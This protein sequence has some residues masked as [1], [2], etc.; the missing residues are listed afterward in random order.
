MISIQPVTPTNVAP[1]NPVVLSSTARDAD[2]WKWMKG[3]ANVPGAT[4]TG[5]VATLNIQS[6]Q[7]I[8]TGNYKVVF[9]NALGSVNSNIAVVTVAQP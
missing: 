6:A 7:T 9:T 1:G 5:N 3:N 8:D 4:G 2:S